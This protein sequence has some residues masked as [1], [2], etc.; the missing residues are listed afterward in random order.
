MDFEF[1]S[2]VMRFLSTFW[3]LMMKS[4]ARFFLIAASVLTIVPARSARAADFLLD[5]QHTS[6]VFAINHFDLSFCYGMFGKYSGS[7]TV[8]MNDPTAA[9]FEITIDAASL[10]TQVEKRDEHLRGPDFFNVKQFPEIKFVSTSVTADGKTLNVT[11]DLTMHGVTKPIVLPLTFIG[12]GVGPYGKER[13]GFAGR[14]TIKRSEFGINA[15]VPKIGD[16][17]TLLLSFEGLKQ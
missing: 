5:D 16:D 14:A 10:D 1:D 7:F 3:N 12:E 2:F 8:D 9:K 13:I 15:Y 4:L 11:G 6:I 17:V